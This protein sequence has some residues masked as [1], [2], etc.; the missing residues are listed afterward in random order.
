MAGETE[1]GSHRHVL[2]QVNTRPLQKRIMLFIALEMGDMQLT[3]ER[4]VKAYRLMRTIRKFDERVY[5]YQA[6]A[7]G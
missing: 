5:W 3:R 7:T 4:P 6:F 1:F 2:T